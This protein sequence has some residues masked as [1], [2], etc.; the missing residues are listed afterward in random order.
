MQCNNLRC[1][2]TQMGVR[3]SRC[4]IVW[5]MADLRHAQG[6][7]FGETVSA[8]RHLLSQAEARV[9]AKGKVATSQ[10]NSS[11]RGEAIEQEVEAFA[12][13]AVPIVVQQQAG[14]F[15][16]RMVPAE[17]LEALLRVGPVLG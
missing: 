8:R 11:S 3:G 7:S 16:C 4:Q 15:D 13:G 2:A 1:T 5:R 6:C 10:D 12:E 9:T 14:A 17:M